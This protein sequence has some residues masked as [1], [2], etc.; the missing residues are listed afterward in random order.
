[1]IGESSSLSLKKQLQLYE[2]QLSDAHS[3]NEELRDKVRKETQKEVIHEGGDNEELHQQLQ[4]YKEELLMLQQKYEMQMTRY[5][6]R[7][8]R[9]K[10]KLQRAK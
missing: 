3:L 7:K 2:K 1:M 6:M 5:M 9:T 4:T 8:A 10:V